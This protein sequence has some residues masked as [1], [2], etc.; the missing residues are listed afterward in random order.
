[1]TDNDKTER[2]SPQWEIGVN[3]AG[4][5]DQWEHHHPRAK[6]ASEAQKQAQQE[7]D[8]DDPVVYMTE[9]PFHD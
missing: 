7:S 2:E 4:Y 8:F 9:G 1:M 5:P 6:T 3:E